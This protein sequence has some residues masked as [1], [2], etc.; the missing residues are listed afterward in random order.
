M[1]TDDVED[2]DQGGRPPEGIKYGQHKNQLGWDPT[3]AKTIKQGTNPKNFS[4]TFTPDPRFRNTRT[5]VKTENADILKNIRPKGPK[6]ITEK[7][8]KDI[9]SGTMLDEDNIL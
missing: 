1:S 7:Q 4:T 2:K 6:I 8:N 3:G 5:T 9:D